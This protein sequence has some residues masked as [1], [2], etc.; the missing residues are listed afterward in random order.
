MTS[1]LR[2]LPPALGVVLVTGCSPSSSAGLTAAEHR[3]VGIYVALLD[4]QLFIAPGLFETAYVDPRP[5]RHGPALSEDVRSEI[6]D[7]FTGRIDVRW[8]SANDPNA[9][10]VTLPP[11]PADANAFEVSVSDRCG[12]VC[13]HSQTYRVTRVGERWQAAAVGGTGIS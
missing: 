9:D 12:N 8:G 3:Q 13:G 5:G 1:L 6:S 10:Y 2:L 11:V 4:R 7:R